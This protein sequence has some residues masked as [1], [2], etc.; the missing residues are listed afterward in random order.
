M[1]LTN[2]VSVWPSKIG[3]FNNPQNFPPPPSIRFPAKENNFLAAAKF[4]RLVMK[5]SQSDV[6]PSFSLKPWADQTGSNWFGFFD[7]GVGEGFL[8]MDLEFWILLK[9]KPKLDLTANI[10]SQLQIKLIFWGF[11]RYLQQSRK[12]PVLESFEKK[13]GHQGESNSWQLLHLTRPF[14]TLRC[15]T[16]I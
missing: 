3:D 8:I 4:W 5:F 13:A 7:N 9:L 2:P 16:L 12:L 14:L 1:M 11:R 6:F 15:L 10:L